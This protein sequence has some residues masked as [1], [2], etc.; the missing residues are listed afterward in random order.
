M[1]RFS[2]WMFRGISGA[3][4]RMQRRFTPAGLILLGA[5]V[6]AAVFGIDTNQ[7]LAYKI[8]TTLMAV[9]ILAAIASR[10]MRARF[11]VL[12]D[13]PRAVA[14]GEPFE[15]RVT[16]RNLGARPV[17]GATLQ[18]DIGDP[19]PGLALYK[20]WSK[21]PTYA[22]WLQAI[23]RNRV[24]HVTP[25]T[26]PRVPA[27][28]EITMRVAGKA[29]RRGRLH[30]EGCSVAVSDPFGFVRRR[31]PVPSTAQL[32]VLPKRYK[33]PPLSLPGARRYQP[34]GVTLSSHVGDSEESIGLRD[35]RPGD[36]VQRI[37]WKSFAKRGEPVVHEYQDEFFERHALILDTFVEAVPG[38]DSH[39]AFEEAVAV[40]ASLAQTIDTQDTL[41]D[42]LFVGDQ[43]YSYT[44]G[45]GQLQPEGL[46]AVLAGVQ[47][48]QGDFRVLHDAVRGKRAAMSGALCVL[49]AWDAPRRELVREMRSTGLEM[50]VLLVT[51]TTPDDPPPWLHVLHPD[52]IQQGLAAL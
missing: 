18:E 11:E 2:W 26:M 50:R 8:I 38:I 34:G 25:P 22:T 32:L 31:F 37:H 46:L 27:R 23:E 14:V 48:A 49:L 47:P 51:E 43:A 9:V 41:L 28:G 19:R 20:S 7:S 29:F 40:A 52:R 24:A 1:W 21:V 6:L 17:D 44:A 33:L 30:F 4:Y 5:L 3:G 13:L 45:R 16:V 36:P 35:Y 10:F 42:L 39:R 15:Y 12:R